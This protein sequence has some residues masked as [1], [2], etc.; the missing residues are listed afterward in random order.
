ML[1]MRWRP[2]T[3]SGMATFRNVVSIHPYF[4]PH[5]GKLDEFL[6]LLPEFVERTAREPD[7]LYYDFTVSD[8]VIH[9][10]EAYAGAEGA[11]AHLENVGDLLQKALA[12]STLE[13]LEF[14]GPEEA[15]EKLR[16]AVGNLNPMWFAFRAGLEKVG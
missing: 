9:C 14:H 3:E 7:C 15:L 5:A 11:L 6:A 1:E 8:S 10:R 13:R 16:P 2:I 12:I 4:K